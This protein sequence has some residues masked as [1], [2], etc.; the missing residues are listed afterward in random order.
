VLTR[1][2]QLTTLLTATIIAILTGAYINVLTGDL[3]ETPRQRLAQTIWHMGSWNVVLGVCVG[4]LLVQ[5]R[6]MRSADRRLSISADELIQDI[7]AAASQSILFPHKS[8][9]LRAIVTVR[10]GT[11]GR[12]VTRYAF[13]TAPDPERVA[14]FP[15][16]FGVT[17]EAY[18]TRSV[19]LHEL[20]ADHV[21]SYED[22]VQPLIF[23]DLRTVL[24]APLLQSNDPNDEPLGVLA[25]DS[26]L[27][28]SKLFFD[29]PEARQLAQLWADIVA[30][31]L[32]VKGT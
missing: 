14:S 17:G 28:P 18:K 20:P 7:L 25:F 32:V 30:K 9:H 8:K 6:A 16:F 3:A 5:Y 12:R 23:P 13:N 10:D 27:P 11:T 15:L 31:L 22:E 24:A 4:L 1:Y 21:S 19:V 2:S 26:V 29:H